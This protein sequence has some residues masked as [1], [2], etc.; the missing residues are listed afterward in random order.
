MSGFDKLKGQHTGICWMEGLPPKIPDS[1]GMFLP[2]RSTVLKSKQRPAEFDHYTREVLRAN[3]LP[4]MAALQKDVPSYLTSVI[5]N[6]FEAATFLGHLR[7]DSAREEKKLSFPSV[8]AAEHSKAFHQAT[9]YFGWAASF[10]YE[11][12][13]MRREHESVVVELEQIKSEKKKLLEEVEVVTEAS[14]GAHK[15]AEMATK[16]VERVKGDLEVAL[17]ENAFLKK[18]IKEAQGE[19]EEAGEGEREA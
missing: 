2:G 10:Q 8:E 3:E 7:D 15:E 12:K 9:Y 6:L 19:I 16:E 5:G 18:K 1:S 4:Y 11:M 17:L 13:G 14:E